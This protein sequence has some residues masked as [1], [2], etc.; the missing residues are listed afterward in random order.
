MCSLFSPVASSFCSLI[1]EPAQ[2]PE[3]LMGTKKQE[4]HKPIQSFYSLWPKGEGP[5]QVTFKCVCLEAK[6]FKERLSSFLF[7]LSV[8]HSNPVLVM[9][10]CLQ[11]CLRSPPHIIGMALCRLLVQY[12]WWHMRWKKCTVTCAGSHLGTKI[13]AVVGAASWNSKNGVSEGAVS[14]GFSHLDVCESVSVALWDISKVKCLISEVLEYFIRQPWNKT[15][16][17]FS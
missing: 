1:Q 13:W 17:L 9:W 4:G 7:T 5:S 15:L 12:W 14:S 16:F 3:F 6:R 10:S 2:G 11:S 8:V